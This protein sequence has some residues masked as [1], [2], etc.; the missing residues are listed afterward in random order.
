MSLTSDDLLKIQEL[1]RTEINE[2]K[3]NSRTLL[4]EFSGFRIDLNKLKDTVAGIQRMLGYEL[5]IT[6]KRLDEHDELHSKHS[7]SIKLLNESMRTSS[8]D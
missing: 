5:P 3:L 7:N 4:D 2:A 6:A 1:I 8:R